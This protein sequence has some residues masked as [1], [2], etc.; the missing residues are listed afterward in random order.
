MLRLRFDVFNDATTVIS[1]KLF[2]V[3]HGHKIFQLT[4]N[5]S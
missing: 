4:V 2:L 5:Y 3:F 1:A